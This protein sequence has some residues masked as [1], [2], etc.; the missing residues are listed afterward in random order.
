MARAAASTTYSSNGFWRSPKYEEV[1]LYAHANMVDARAGIARYF[2]FVNH[3]RPHQSSTSHKLS[4][5][6]APLDRCRNNVAPARGD[7]G[8][9]EVGKTEDDDHGPVPDLENGVHLTHPLP[10]APSF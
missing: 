2:D 9:P 10:Q 3:Q 1:Y 8:A 6:P 7:E 4:V 5:S